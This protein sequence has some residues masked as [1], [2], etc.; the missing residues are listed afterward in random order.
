MLLRGFHI[1]EDLPEA[2]FLALWFVECT[3]GIQEQ[4][5]EEGKEMLL[6]RLLN[7]VVSIKSLSFFS[8]PLSLSL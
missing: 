2:F 4:K 7:A 5:A 8:R 1:V 6:C 3:H